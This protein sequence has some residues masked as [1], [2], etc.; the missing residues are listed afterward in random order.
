VVF[1]EIIA[2]MLRRWQG[3]SIPEPPTLPARLA[4][5]VHNRSGFHRA[6]RGVLENQEGTL[7]FRPQRSQESSL[8]AQVKASPTY[9]VVPAE[10]QEMPERSVVQAAWFDWPLLAIAQWVD[11]T[12]EAALD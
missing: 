6:I 11:S 5:S 8:F 3:F 2:P 10:L 9:A 4:S 7:T 1:S 12:A